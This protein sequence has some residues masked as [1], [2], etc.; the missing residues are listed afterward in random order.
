MNY[1][2]IEA[3]DGSQQMAEIC[4]VLFI[5]CQNGNRRLFFFAAF[6]ALAELS[7]RF[8]KEAGLESEPEPGFISKVEPEQLLAP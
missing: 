3:R 5:P 7:E 2:I 6:L 1:S 4:H 8:F